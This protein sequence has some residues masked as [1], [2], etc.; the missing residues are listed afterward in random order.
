MRQMSSNKHLLL[1]RRRLH[2]RR[3]SPSAG[4]SNAASRYQS[5]RPMHGSVVP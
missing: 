2:V 4:L 3:C 5:R 1:Q